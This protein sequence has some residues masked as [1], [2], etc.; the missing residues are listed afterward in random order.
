MLKAE[1]HEIRME[2]RRLLVRIAELESQQQQQQ[3]Q[4]CTACKTLQ[5]SAVDADRCRT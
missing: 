3:Q 4:Q 2:K 1:L 5:V